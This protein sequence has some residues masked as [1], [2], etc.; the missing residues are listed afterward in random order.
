MKS[1]FTHYYVQAHE[2]HKAPE[3]VYH[4]KDEKS[5]EYFHKFLS[6]P[7]AMEL[8][9]SE[10]KLAPKT[11]FRIVKLVETYTAGEWI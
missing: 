10:K 4:T 9:K 5:G 8:L 2:P 6:R 3:I 1:S 11:Q 7:K